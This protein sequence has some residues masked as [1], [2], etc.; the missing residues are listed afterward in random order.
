MEFAADKT[1]ADLVLIDLGP[2]LGALNRAVLASSDYFITPVAPDLFS[3]QG[4]ENLGNKLVAWRKEWDQCNAAWAGGVLSIPK[5]RPRYL[6]Y[7]VQ[8]HNIRSSSEDGM[9]AGWS[10]YGNQ[11]ESAIAKN[12]VEKLT[13][14]EQVIQWED[15]AF[16]LGQIPNL[17]SLIP[18]SLEARKHVF[19]CGSSDGLRGGHIKRATASQDH[20][21]QIVETLENVSTW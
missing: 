8:M 17:H 11:L 21:M 18:Y 20:F 7:V 1:K 14:L 12:I 5:G 15:D 9:T 19:D 16:K 3:I 10:I 13:P 4:T 6:G 2:N